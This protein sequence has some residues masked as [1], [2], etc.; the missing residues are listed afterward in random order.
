MISYCKQK[1]TLKDKKKVN[2][3]LSSEFL[4]QGP[5]VLK[6]ETKLSRVFGAKYS[7]ALANGTCGLYIAIKVLNLKK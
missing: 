4:T 2:D 7:K 5:E 1:I 3:V 6:F